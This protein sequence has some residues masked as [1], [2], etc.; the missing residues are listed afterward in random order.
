MSSLGART[1]NLEYLLQPPNVARRFF[2][3]VFEGILQFLG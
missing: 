2:Q 3:V 1:K